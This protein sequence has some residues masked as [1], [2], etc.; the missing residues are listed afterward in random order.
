MPEGYTH[1]SIALA[2]AAAAGWPVTSR[3]AFLAGAN[4]PDMLFSFEA[5]KPAARRRMDLAAFGGRMHTE[6][7]GAFLRGLCR[8]AVTPAQKDYFMGFLCHY[9][10]DTTVHPYVEAVTRCCAPYGGKAGHGYFESALDSYLHKRDTGCAA[11]PV[12][13]M[14]P[15]LTGAALAEVNA[16]LQRAILDTYGVEI[17]R[18]YLADAFFDN[19]RVRSLF[20]ARTPLRRGLFWLIEPLFGGRGVLTGHLTPA[21]LR[22]V[23]R[24]DSRR[25]ISLPTL[26]HEPATGRPRAENISQLLDMALEYS[27]QLLREATAPCTGVDLFWP[28]VG[29]R[30]YVK[31]CETPL[32]AAPAVGAGPAPAAPEA[33]AADAAAPGPKDPPDL[34]LFACV[35]PAD[36]PE[37]APAAPEPTPTGPET[38]RC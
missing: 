18:E 3:A 32:S 2:A 20:C 36:A 14:C 11:V 19:Y 8:Y 6:R 25:G 31:G 28:L 37:A 16:Q 23:S 30:D 26:W 9:A 22:G 21:R 10:A 27:T 35:M 29:S 7:T 15:R 13:D 33:E 17:R 24:R 1:A 5:W 12:D 4:G 34:P 38:A